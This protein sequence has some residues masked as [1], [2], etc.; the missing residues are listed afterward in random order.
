M[1]STTFNFDITIEAEVVVIRRNQVVEK[2]ILLKEIRR[3]QT[4]EQEIQKKLEKDKGQAWENNRIVYIKEKIYVSNNW[5][6]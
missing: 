2:T 3:N 5:K 6:I 1:K 4:K